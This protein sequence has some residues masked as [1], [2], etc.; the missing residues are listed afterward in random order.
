MFEP[1]TLY[2]HEGSRLGEVADR[3]HMQIRQRHHDLRNAILDG[4]SAEHILQC[5]SELIVTTLLHFESEERA[6][7]KNPHQ[8]LLAHQL[9][10]TEMIANLT[11]I[12]DQLGARKLS[13]AMELLKFFEGRL[14]Y[15]LDFEDAALER[16]LAN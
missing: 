9:L 12:S 2:R 1:L 10:H 7:G 13:G 4:S 6:I 8:C 14:S 3:Q 11:R 5:S 15:H 16:Q